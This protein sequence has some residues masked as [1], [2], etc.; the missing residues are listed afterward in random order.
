MIF[1]LW[2]PKISSRIRGVLILPTGY[3]VFYL[4]HWLEANSMELMGLRIDIEPLL[5]CLIASCIAGNESKNRRK[6]ANILHKSAPYIFIP[7]FTLTGS[8]LDLRA[9]LDSLGLAA[10]LVFSRAFVLFA[11]TFL[12]GKYILKQ[13]ASQYRYLWMTLLPQAGTLLGL[14]NQLK[15]YGTWTQPIVSACVAA[16]IINNI[17]GSKLL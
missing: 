4:G 6:F 5:L 12:A 7:F 9:L 16:L 15:T 2:I 1:Y 10:L 17:I 3:A 14:V 13:D 11:V 8:S